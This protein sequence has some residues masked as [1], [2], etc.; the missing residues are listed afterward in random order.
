MTQFG[1]PKSEFFRSLQLHHLLSGIFGSS[2]SA[3][4]DEK[5]FNK[6]LTYYGKGHE[7]SVHYSM[8]T[9][10]LFNVASSSHEDVGKGSEPHFWMMRIGKEFVTTLKQGTKRYASCTFG[11]RI[12]SNGHPSFCLDWST[13]Q[14]KLSE[15]GHLVHVLQYVPVQDVW[16]KTHDNL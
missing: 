11:S 1:N 9:Q 12:S 10:S 2:V 16:A 8:L 15:A 14:V 7:A 6:A 3:P 5:L 4:K 13:T